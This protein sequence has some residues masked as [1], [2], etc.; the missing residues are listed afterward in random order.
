MKTTDFTTSILVD[1]TP[2]EVFN[3]I[4]Y[5]GGWWQGEVEGDT[6]RLHDEFTYRMEDMHFSKQRVVEVTP[7]K[8]VV[9]LITESQLNF[10][11]DKSEWTGTKISFE[12]SKIKN[13]TQLL[14]IR[15]PR[16]MTIRN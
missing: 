11:K 5:V 10:T 2:S 8:K 7:G 13:K 9:W 1:Q 4:N 6:N 12:T 3:A 16:H 15:I 14:F